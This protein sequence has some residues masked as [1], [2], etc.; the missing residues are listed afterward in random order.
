VGMWKINNKVFN[1]NRL[2]AVFAVEIVV[3]ILCFSS[4]IV[5]NFLIADH[6]SSISTGNFGEV[7]GK[8]L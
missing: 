3:N 2:S 6:Y 1:F 8:V 4:Y 7:C 5:E